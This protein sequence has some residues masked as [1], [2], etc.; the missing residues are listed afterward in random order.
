MKTRITHRP[1]GFTLIEISLVIGIIIGLSAIIGFSVNA[2]QGWQKAKAG[3]L[4]LQ[5]VYAAQRGYMADYPTA[6]I[7]AV[8]STQLLSY[9][10]QGWSTIPVVTGLNGESLT[11]NCS[12][13]PPYLMLGSNR[14]DPSNTQSD[15]LWDVGE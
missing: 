13:M 4:A 2:V 5:A 7:D 11:I 14:Y 8:T 1:H 12:V 10:P 3:S 15:G 6:S 9:L